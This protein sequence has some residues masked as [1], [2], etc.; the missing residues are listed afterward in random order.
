M[1]GKRLIARPMPSALAMVVAPRAWVHLVPLIILDELR[2]GRPI[3][4]WS[5]RQADRQQDVAVS[6]ADARAMT[7]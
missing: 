5:C 1:A 6:S 2:G 4:L 7:T 3:P